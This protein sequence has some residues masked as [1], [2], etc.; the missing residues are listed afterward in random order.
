MKFEFSLYSSEWL[1]PIVLELVLIL[2]ILDQT[3]RQQQ[4]QQQPHLK[5]QG[6]V[7][8]NIFHPRLSLDFVHVKEFTANFGPCLLHR[9]NQLM[10]A[11]GISGQGYT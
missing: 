3:H 4:G 11:G 6:I 10:A 5:D 2:G 7:F 9:I 8:G 1:S